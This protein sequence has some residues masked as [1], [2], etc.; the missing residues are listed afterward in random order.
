MEDNDNR[1]IWVKNGRNYR[2]YRFP[3][4]KNVFWSL[5]NVGDGQGFNP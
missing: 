4:S 5:K 1:L 3:R 2:A